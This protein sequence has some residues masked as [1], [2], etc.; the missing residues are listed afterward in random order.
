MT[1]PIRNRLLFLVIIPAIC[2]SGYFIIRFII[3][4]RLD[5]HSYQPGARDVQF[6]LPDLYQQQWEYNGI[7]ANSQVDSFLVEITRA[8]SKSSPTLTSIIQN[9]LNES[10]WTQQ[11]EITWYQFPT[12]R[13]M[14]ILRLSPVGGNR[15]LM[16][17]LKVEAV[18]EQNYTRVI[19]TNDEVR[20][21][22]RFFWPRFWAARRF[23][24]TSGSLE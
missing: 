11:D 21:A 2:I 10:G 22:E 4:P 9:R 15:T 6:W 8:D 24:E 14:T 12:R 23:Y 7:Y 3:Y 17:F 5:F 13:R 20:W 16:A 1:K 18:Q 19:A